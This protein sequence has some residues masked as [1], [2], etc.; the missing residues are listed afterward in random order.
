M[1]EIKL[2]EM[3]DFGD[4]E[5]IMCDLNE[6][7]QGNSKLISKANFYFNKGAVIEDL[8]VVSLDILYLGE[9]TRNMS[10]HEINE[11]YGN[12]DT[13]FCLTIVLDEIDAYAI[14]ALDYKRET[15][16]DKEL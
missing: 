1:K 10:T 13:D 9:E 12:N 11:D 4:E 16:C 5:Y 2:Y 7:D 14:V 6:V 8:T 3:L 15:F